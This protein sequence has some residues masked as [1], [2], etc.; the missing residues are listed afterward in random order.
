MA[1][2]EYM[3]AAYGIIW[4]AILLYFLSLGRKEREIRKEIYALRASLQELSGTPLHDEG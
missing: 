4:L 1:H 2:L 3:A